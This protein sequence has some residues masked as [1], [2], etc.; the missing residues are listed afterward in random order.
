M[1]QTMNALV[2]FVPV[3]C[4]WARRSRKDNEIEWR[5]GDL[6]EMHESKIW[7]HCRDVK[8]FFNS[9]FVFSSQFLS[10]EQ[11]REAMPGPTPT[12]R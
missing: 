11:D 1:G 9:C 3:V 6:S 10:T 5:P 12:N 2:G 7:G 8:D 4:S